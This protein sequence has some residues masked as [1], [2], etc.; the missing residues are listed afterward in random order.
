[1]INFEKKMQEKRRS[2]YVDIMVRA[3]KMGLMNPSEDVDRMMDIESADVKFNLRLSD[4]LNADDFDF[5]HDFIGIRDSIN[6][7][8]GFPAT[9]FGLFV[10]RFAE[11]E[12]ED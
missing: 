4:W 7:D 9:D 6:R 12:V 1:M 10:P 8:N 11:S 2:K 5:A 3:T